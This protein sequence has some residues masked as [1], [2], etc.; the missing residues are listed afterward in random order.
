MAGIV[1]DP[2]IAG[3]SVY[4]KLVLNPK[5]LYRP[6]YTGVAPRSGLAF[7][8]TPKTVFRGGFGIF[9]NLPLLQTADQ[10]S[11]G[12]PFASTGITNNPPMSLTPLSVAGIP[13]LTDL[14]GNPLPPGGS[15]RN[16]QPNTP[17]NLQ[18]V[19]AFFGGPL[20]TN[21]LCTNLHNGY[22]MSGNVMLER[23][24]PGDISFQM[25]YVTNNAVGLY[26]S[27]YPNAYVGA[28]PQYT[29]YSLADPGLGEFQLTDNHGHSTYNS[30][31]VEACKVSP[32][33]GIT[34][35]V[36]Y[37]YSKSI[38]NASTVINGP[39]AISGM[40]QNNPFC[41][42][43]EKAVSGF[44]FTHRFVTNF[45]FKLLLDNW[46]AL[47][48]V[49]QRLTH[50]WQMTSII[51]WQSGFP[52][53]VTSPFGTKEYGTDAYV[54]FQATR[55]DLV[56]QP[57]LNTGGAPEEQ[58]FSTAVVNDGRSLGQQYFATPGALTTGVQDHPGNLGRNTFRTS[59]FS[60]FDFS[61]I[62]DTALTE[63]KT[64]QF[65]A[66][67]FNLFNQHA[68]APPPAVLGSPGFGIANNTVLPERQIQL[69]LR[70]IF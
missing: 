31:Q 54:G 38:D 67:L 36:S 12:F 10:N 6:D 65:R 25:G 30:L 51:E 58:F 42:R 61:L 2:S 47:S 28:L 52:F 39:V 55:P 70:L 46:R 29:P 41:W 49:P 53:T 34:F 11:F 21:L 5:P 27:E 33:H 66:E 57:T 45:I 7:R 48:A 62:K 59:P 22:M 4:R 13:T 24:L 17:V 18:P 35:Q 37:T 1:D 23:Q 20:L 26:A 43:C 16:L 19:A 14:Q 3:G 40:L 15:T 32:A 8:I 56:Q 60:N 69:A 44:D 64:L 50:G 68:F 9:T 63:G